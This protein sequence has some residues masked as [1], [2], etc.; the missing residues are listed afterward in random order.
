M[1]LCNKIKVFWKLSAICKKFFPNSIRTKGSKM[2]QIMKERKN[3]LNSMSIVQ[4]SKT[5]S[6]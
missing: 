2:L 5:Q 3:L 4:S 6:N 1:N